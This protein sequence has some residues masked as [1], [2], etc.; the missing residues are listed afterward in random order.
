MQR[1][2]NEIN[3][4]VRWLG[5]PNNLKAARAERRLISIGQPAL[6]A[7]IEATKDP[8]PQV[9]LRAVYAL[10]V[11]GDHRAYP[12]LS[13]LVTNYNRPNSEVR[14]E[15]IL[16]LGRLGDTRAIGILIDILREAKPVE[17]P[18][19]W[20]AVALSN[21]GK[22]A[23]TQLKEIIEAG[24]DETRKLACEAI[25]VINKPIDLTED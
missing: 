12:V 16:A 9:Q 15:A 8:N 6:D 18:P 20:A 24:N 21:I 22:P 17:S 3:N 19:Q 4:L 23:I 2:S 14:Y 25:E 1:N 11:I 13:E 5:H 10:G 7:L